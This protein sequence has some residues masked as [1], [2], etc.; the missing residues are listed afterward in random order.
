MSVKTKIKS[1]IINC[2]KESKDDF[3]KND[4]QVKLETSSI[5][6]EAKVAVNGDIDNSK[7]TWLYNHLTDNF[8]I[9]IKLNVSNSK[10]TYELKIKNAKVTMISGYKIAFLSHDFSWDADDDMEKVIFS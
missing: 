3:P 9:L 10:K 8:E 2:G 1:L 6:S 7:I 4:V 5:V